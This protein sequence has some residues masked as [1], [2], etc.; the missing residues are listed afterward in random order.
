[1]INNTAA[2]A[3][4]AKQVRTIKAKVELY[5]GSTLLNTFNGTD[6]IKEF[7]VER[8][9]TGRFFGWY[10]RQAITKVNRR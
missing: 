5:N 10:L 9:G 3:E 6:H 4:L 8:A 2:Q 7:T 1:M